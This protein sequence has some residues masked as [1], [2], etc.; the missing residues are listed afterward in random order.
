MNKTKKILSLFLSLL[1]VVTSF[2]A[3]PFEAFADDDG[4]Y[5]MCWDCGQWTDDYC[6]NCADDTLCICSSCYDE[7]HCDECDGCYINNDVDSCGDGCD[8]QICKDCAMADGYHCIECG[9]CFRNSYE[10]DLCVECQKCANCVSGELCDKCHTCTECNFHCPECNEC[11]AFECVSGAEDH[12]EN[13][14]VICDMCGECVLAL[15]KELCDYCGLCED[16]CEQNS[17][18]GC[19]MCIEDPEYDEHVCPECG[20]CFEETEKCDTCG[21]CL[22]CCLSEAV[23]MGCSCS[24]YCHEELDDSHFCEDCGEC[25]G[26]TDP[27]ETCESA[28]EYR[29]IDCCEQLSN[30]NGCDCASPVCINDPEWEDHFNSEHNG[31][32][33]EHKA[34]AQST[35]SINETHH[36][37]DCKYCDAPEHITSKAAH[38]YDELGKCKVCGFTKNA[39]IIITKQP[40]SK[41][42]DVPDINVPYEQWQ[43]PVFNVTAK[44]LRPLSYQWQYSGTKAFTKPYDF[45]DEGCSTNSLLVTLSEDN[46]FGLYGAN[47][48]EM[49]IRC[50]ITDDSGNVAYSNVVTL[51]VKHVF[52]SDEIKYDEDGHYIK[53]RGSGCEEWSKALNHTYDKWTWNAERTERTATCTVCGYKATVSVHKHYIDWVSIG[54]Y[55][56]PTKNTDIKEYSYTDSETGKKYLVNMYKHEGVCMDPDC[57]YVISGHHNWGAWQKATATPTTATAKGGMHRICKDCEFDDDILRK[58]KNGNDLYWEFGV[59]PVSV[60]GGTMNNPLGLIKNG[61]TITLTPEKKENYTF[62]G[63]KLTR[64]MLSGSSYNVYSATISA[65]TTEYYGFPE[66]L[67]HLTIPENYFKDAGVWTLTAQYAEG[68]S[69]ANTEIVG[70]TEATCGHFGY[71]GDTVCADC[72]HLIKRGQEIDKPAHKNVQVVKNDIPLTDKYGNPVYKKNG[73]PIYVA[74]AYNEGDCQYGERGYTGD[75]YCADCGKIVERGKAVMVHHWEVEE[76]LKE[77]TTTSKGRAVYVCPSCGITKEMA[78]DYSGPDYS[79]TASMRKVN[80]TFTYGEEVSPVIIDFKRTGRNADDIVKIDK[81]EIEAEDNI[82]LKQTG[83]MQISIEPNYYNLGDIGD[84]TNLVDVYFLLKDGSHIWYSQT[85]GLEDTTDNCFIQTNINILKS[86]ETYTLK[87]YNGGVYDTSSKSV[88]E[89]PL[90]FHAGDQIRIDAADQKNVNAWVVIDDN[91]GYI[92]KYADTVNANFDIFYHSSFWMIMPQNDV[93]IIALDNNVTNGFVQIDGKTVYIEN[94]KLV[95]G[96]KQID[97]STYY[98]DDS[99]FMQTGL[100]TIDGKKYYFGKNGAMYTKRLI[101][102]SGKK[103]YMGADGAAY[104]KKL[105]SV[106]GKKYYMGADGVAYTNRLISVNG[107]KYYMGK[108]GVAYTSKLISVNGKKYYMGKDGVAYT[109]KLASISGKKYYFG[110]DGVAYKS[111]LISVSGKKYYIGKDCIAYK[112]KFASLS[113]KKYYFGSDCVMYKSKT[114]SVSGVKWVADKNG[115]CKKK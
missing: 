59:H 73:D 70:K 4:N 94:N 67:Y 9:E 82:V 35:W 90:Q 83:D 86:K 46:C 34:S 10:D 14:C 12:C 75:T 101:S 54:Q 65:K 112:S 31:A 40:T 96:W 21:W 78:L 7:Y 114:F 38:T 1:M 105:I 8:N 91:S 53:C 45:R 68:C 50:K 98:F 74:R 60:V 49:Y 84:P 106:S 3:L 47:D 23:D 69:H 115:V 5:R 18:D 71:T 79:V 25:F 42:V 89:T 81:V 97:G 93:S 52:D 26:I 72:G 11:D 104:T 110:K 95:T 103:Y 100:K 109:S 33:P 28:G 16:C 39:A 37:K 36:W 2:F 62:T 108:D 80:F 57:D 88:I 48:N 30:A 99:G 19:G 113:G 44:S 22:D 13:E 63:W 66:D 58:D 77:S 29:C 64:E 56:Q 51:T 92:I 24:E 102:V 27:C 55:M 61:E 20:A 43:R 87:V 111:K 17:C 41:V 107:K 32:N 6:E 15:D 76:V 85:F